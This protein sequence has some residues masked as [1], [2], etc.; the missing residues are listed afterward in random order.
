M[1]MP[2]VE[3]GGVCIVHMG[4]AN[5]IEAELERLGCNVLF[6]CVPGWKNTPG[7]PSRCLAVL[8]PEVVI[9]FHFD[10]FTSPIPKSRPVRVLPTADLKGFMEEVRRHAPGTVVLVPDP[11]EVMRF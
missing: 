9:P 8:R 6:M 2:R 7:Y 4:S 10:D 3:V 5:F 1:F 11:H